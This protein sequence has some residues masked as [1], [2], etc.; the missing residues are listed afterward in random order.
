MPGQKELKD[1]YNLLLNP[2][3]SCEE[4]QSL[5]FSLNRQGAGASQEWEVVAQEN[6]NRAICVAWP[7]FI[8]THTDKYTYYIIRAHGIEEAYNDTA[9]LFANLHIIVYIHVYIYI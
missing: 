6:Q 2:A 8:Y 3:E 1:M 5:C 9:H 4:P 7:L